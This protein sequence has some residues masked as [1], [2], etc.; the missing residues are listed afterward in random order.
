MS[1][2]IYMYVYTVYI[3]TIYTTENLHL[4]PDTE[5]EWHESF[6]EEGLQV[7]LRSSSSKVPDVLVRSTS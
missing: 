7:P 3:H 1:T 5:K 4:Q 2:C 6:K